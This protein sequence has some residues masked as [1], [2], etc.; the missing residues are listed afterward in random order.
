MEP[1][2]RMWGLDG[3]SAPRQDTGAGAEVG[4]EQHTPL[5]RLLERRDGMMA[6]GI[7]AEGTGW[8]RGQRQKAWPWAGT[9]EKVVH[10]GGGVRMRKCGL[11]SPAFSEQ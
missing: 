7:M 11:Q 6:E 1:P 5:P 9:G 4:R 10:W 8:T 3:P 2:R